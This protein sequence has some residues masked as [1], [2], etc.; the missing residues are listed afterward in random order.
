MTDRKHFRIHVN[1]VVQG[2]GF[3]PFIYSQAV[4]CN[5]DGTVI[6][7]HDGVIIH[8]VGSPSD[9][10]A[11]VRAISE[12]AP[13]ASQIET[14]TLT[15]LPVQSFS[16]FSILSSERVADG[17]TQI[18]A[19]LAL[20]EDCRREL[21]D[22]S[23]RRFNYPLIN[24][25]NCG[26][27]FTIIQGLPYDRPQTTMSE[28][29]MCADCRHEYE[30]PL[31][32]RFHAQPVAC[33]DCG[34]SFRFLRAVNSEW[35]E[36]SG[37]AIDRIVEEL[38]E[39]K[40]ALIQGVGGFHL[41]CDALNEEAVKR[42]RERKQRERKPLAVMM[43]SETML[44]EHCDATAEELYLLKSPK[45][46]IVLI[47]K[48]SGCKIA[49]SV[50]P[51]NPFLG[52]MLAYSPLHSLLLNKIAKPLV[53]TSANLSDEP[54][55]YLQDD[56][57]E[58]MRPI[59]DA[60]ILHERRIHIFADDSIVRIINTT[61]RVM[62]RARGYVPEPVYVS[63]SFKRQMLAFGPQMK[64]TFCMG[65]ENVALLS[66]HLGD[67][68][69][70]AAVHAQQAALNHFLKLYEMKIELVAC[71]LHFDYTS[72]R[73]AEEWAA[74][75]DLPLVRVQHHHAH[76]VSCLAENHEDGK[77]IGI[78]LDGTGFGTDGNIWGGEVLI[79][80]AK[81]FQRYA[82]L[83]EIAMPGGEKAARE[84]WRMTVSWLNR[85]FGESWIDLDI[86]LVKE[87][88]QSIGERKLRTLVEPQLM[89][90]VYPKTT[91]M[92]RLFDAVSALVCFGANSQFEGQA[93]M[94]LEW[95]TGNEH[96]AGYLIE[97]EQVDDVLILNPGPLF[98]ELVDDIANRKNS[99]YISSRFHEAIVDVFLR[100]C[101]RIKHETGLATAALSGGC[102]QNSY[103]L[104][105][106]M[107][108]LQDDGFRVL[109]H[110]KIP[111]NDG[112]VSLGQAVIANEQTG[113]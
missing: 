13:P 103:L 11:F 99:S 101:L 33:H 25:T 43:V 56:A 66:Q 89:G 107:N 12:K 112:G 62:R 68:D 86:P 96:Q 34:P 72:T 71:D 88:R 54:I 60:A 32:R 23:D 79:G 44:N 90:S 84:P 47:R 49:L 6:N 46:P 94:E 2:V 16:G 100:C 3:R 73:L 35:E 22:K 91:S 105:R 83:A 59:A 52:V 9:I 57:L 74:E 42:L 40:I 108:K 98:K 95:L 38:S 27:R 67:L 31:D 58:R 92:G 104:T 1:G 55:S 41:A 102:F 15:E 8:A 20:C 64:N 36:D 14:I 10:D 29:E 18:P 50:A 7:R 39:G 5:I 69:S 93:A 61:P 82:H 4:H 81:G 77:A 70:E 53:M 17:F 111:C 65:R 19:D 110:S 24:C 80:D 45:A 28:F 87:L 97:I 78:I 30:N 76:L 75:R 21:L 51:A 63:Q 85:T 26:P 48:S 37:N 113:E 106:L 109:T